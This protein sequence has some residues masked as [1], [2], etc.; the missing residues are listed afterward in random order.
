MGRV[1]YHM[2]LFVP[3]VQ[4]N[5]MLPQHIFTQPARITQAI[6]T[7]LD[8]LRKASPD[9]DETVAEWLLVMEHLAETVKILYRHP[10]GIK[11]ITQW[12]VD[13]THKPQADI[14]QFLNELLQKLNQDQALMKVIANE[15]LFR[16][17]WKLIVGL[18]VC[19]TPPVLFVV[20]LP[21][22]ANPAVFV[23]VL[24]LT[25]VLI[26]LMGHFLFISK[27]AN[28]FYASRVLKQTMPASKP[29]GANCRDVFFTDA[30]YE[31]LR[32]SL[33]QGCHIPETPLQSGL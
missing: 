2:N 6:G 22:I 8:E 12:S 31:Y 24:L 17:V 23:P 18:I 13:M 21:F 5:K 29:D 16:S 7:Y 14:H 25:C 11:L 3:I 32:N 30:R 20:L 9:P 28:D 19:I 10:K 27:G 4:G 15:H 1:F 33:Q 26:P